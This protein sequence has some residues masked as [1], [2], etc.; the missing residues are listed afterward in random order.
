MA[1]FKRNEVI[2][3]MTN[4]GFTPVFYH[5]D[6]HIAKQVLKACYQGGVRVFEFTNRDAW[7]HEVFAELKQYAVA[8]FPDLALGIGSVVDAATAALYVQIDADFIVSPIVN[9]AMAKMCHRRGVLWIPGCG[10]LTEMLNGVELGADIVKAFP[11]GQLGGPA[12][13]KAVKGPCP[14]LNIMPTG[15]V[16]TETENLRGWFE[17]GVTC[18]GIGSKL[19]DKTIWQTSNYEALQNK[20]VQ[21]VATIAQVKQEMAKG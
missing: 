6:I 18:V 14:W 7:A 10:T 1:R 13:I 12:F 2:Q 3:M 17:A 16:S 5:S 4:S 8:N 9:E 19:I 11:A 21:I 15:G 20:V